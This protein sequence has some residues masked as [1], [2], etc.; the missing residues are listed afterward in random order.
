MKLH[1]SLHHL[2]I[3]ASAAVMLG[4]S[5]CHLNFTMV[6]GYFFDYT[7][8]TAEFQDQGSIDEGVTKIKINNQFG[9]VKISHSI[10]QPGW[11]WNSTVWAE[12][13]ELADQFI[14]EFVMDVVTDG[15]TQ[16]WT[17][18]LPE[19][20]AELNGVKSNLT[21]VVPSDVEI[22]LENRHGDVDLSELTGPLVAKNSHGN[23]VAN[24]I[25]GGSLTVSHGN[26]TVLMST[27][28]ISI[29]SSHGDVNV[30]G[31]VGELT[32]DARHSEIRA[33]EV[34]S[35]VDVKT[36]HDNI[37][38]SKLQGDVILNNSHGKITATELE[39]SVTTKNR[40]GNTTI[41]T[42]GNTVSADSSH[43]NIRVTVTNDAFSSVELETSF[44]SIE[45]KLPAAANPSIKMDTS[46]GDTNSEFESMQGSSQSVILKNQHGDI[47]VKQ[48]NE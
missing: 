20:S 27:G 34:S 46:F 2:M 25:A 18:L 5:G 12:S 15:N 36:T 32:I 29:D 17:V 23:L 19:S 11:T 16:T 33:S 10:D 40:H 45:L 13:Q 44:G 3:A 14:Q 4:F 41:S 37:I 35:K 47:E 30:D 7:G 26:T 31:I 1:P 42:S 24:Q 43:G 48:S 8:E 39:G 28:N 6:D 9:N 38:V 22:Q 21:L